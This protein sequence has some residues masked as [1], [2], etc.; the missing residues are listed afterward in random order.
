[1]RRSRW[2]VSDRRDRLPADWEARRRA[3]R[4]R[5]RGLCQATRHAPDCDGVGTDCD[6]IVQGDDHGLDNLQWLSHACHKAKTERENADR[7]ARRAAMRRHP[8]EPPP[9]LL[10]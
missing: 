6:H 3:V 7:N 8:K 10:R 4:D 5:A 9:G 2:Y 1:M